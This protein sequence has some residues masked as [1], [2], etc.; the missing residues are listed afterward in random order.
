MQDVYDKRIL[1]IE[2][3]EEQSGQVETIHLH[4]TT[5]TKE[6]I[7]FYLAIIIRQL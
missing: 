7:S 6:I 4:E 5:L 1:I 2:I 3:V